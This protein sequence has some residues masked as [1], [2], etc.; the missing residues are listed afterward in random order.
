MI[1]NKI[2]NKITSILVYIAVANA[3]TI[4][5]DVLGYKPIFSADGKTIINKQVLDQY[6]AYEAAYRQAQKEGVEEPGEFK[7]N[8]SEVQAERVPEVIQ[9]NIPGRVGR[10][11]CFNIIPPIFTSSTPEVTRKDR[12]KVNNLVAGHGR[13]Y[14]PP[15]P[16]L[17]LQQQWEKPSTLD[18]APYL[19]QGVASELP[20]VEIT[21]IT[22]SSRIDPEALETIG[23]A[24]PPPLAI[25]LYAR[26]DCLSKSLNHSPD[27]VIR[28][29]DGEGTQFVSINKL[30][31]DTGILEAQSWEE[32]DQT[33]DWW[34]TAIGE[35]PVPRTT[36][37]NTGGLTLRPAVSTGSDKTAGSNDSGDKLTPTR[38]HVGDAYLSAK[39]GPPEYKKDVVE[40]GEDFEF[41]MQDDALDS[42]QS[43]KRMWPGIEDYGYGGPNKLDPR[44]KATGSEYLTSDW[45]PEATYDSETEEVDPGRGKPESDFSPSQKGKIG[46]SEFLLYN[47]LSDPL[48]RERIR[49]REPLLNEGDKSDD[50]VLPPLIPDSSS[51]NELP[52]QAQDVSELWAQSNTNTITDPEF[53]ALD[54]YRFRSGGMTS[55]GSNPE[56]DVRLDILEE[57]YVNELDELE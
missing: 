53:E 39:G 7:V 43:M 23:P 42:M 20:K 15:Y 44:V 34:S 32:L 48:P 46:P 8:W 30:H 22:I 57:D 38:A 21:G 36:Q 18:K 37:T 1:K 19:M 11:R 12:F 28:Y 35:A 49:E 29:F 17:N 6:V 47:P 24:G 45:I 27:A 40:I 56:E 31:P 14:F 26:R 3:Y 50:S 5:F 13:E 54:L 33:S 25:A 4:K 41:Y 9:H 52:L 10:E 2:T 51:D 55:G 16:L